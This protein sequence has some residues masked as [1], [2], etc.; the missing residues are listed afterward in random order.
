MLVICFKVTESF[1]LDTFR[2]LLPHQNMTL[3]VICCCL[4]QWLYLVLDVCSGGCELYIYVFLQRH[5][6]QCL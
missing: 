4:F 6:A 2:L 3:S 5:T 1:L